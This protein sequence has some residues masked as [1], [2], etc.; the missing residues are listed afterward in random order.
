M[1]FIRKSSLR[2]LRRN[3]DQ[4]LS[5]DAGYAHMGDIWFESI[6]EAAERELISPPIGPDPTSI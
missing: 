4:E 6:K 2:T 5:T 3:T 1:G